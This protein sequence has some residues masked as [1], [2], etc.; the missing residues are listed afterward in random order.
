MDDDDASSNDGDDAPLG[1]F[2]S[3]AFAD[4]DVEVDSVEDVREIREDV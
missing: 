2:L 3:Q 4:V 1:T